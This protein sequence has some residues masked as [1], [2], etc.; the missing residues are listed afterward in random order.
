MRPVKSPQVLRQSMLSAP[1]ILILRALRHHLQRHLQDLLA[2]IRISAWLILAPTNGDRH[3]AMEFNRRRPKAMEFNLVARSSIILSTYLCVSTAVIHWNDL[4]DI[5]LPVCPQEYTLTKT[6]PS[7]DF[8]QDPEV[9]Y[10]YSC[11]CEQNM[12]LG[13][14]WYFHWA[15]MQMITRG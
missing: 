12:C 9:V 15:N 1:G 10:V 5:S 8:H 4:G 7:I 6:K 11:G 13:L 14:I 3:T 2:R